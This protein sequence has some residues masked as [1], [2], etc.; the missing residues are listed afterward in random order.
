VRATRPGHPT[1]PDSP[2]AITTSSVFE[3]FA[4][5]EQ[6]PARPRAEPSNV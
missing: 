4:I 5:A 3:R 6:V 1:S 2:S